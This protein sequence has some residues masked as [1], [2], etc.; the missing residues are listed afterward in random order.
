MSRPIRRCPERLDNLGVESI[1]DIAKR[2]EL[3]V[4]ELETEVSN[5]KNER[6]SDAVRLKESETHKDSLEKEIKLVK[7]DYNSLVKKTNSDEEVIKS[8]N[9]DISKLNIEIESR[10]K[11]VSSKTMMGMKN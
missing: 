9:E 10:K 11:N 3:A 1:R 4:L 2:L 8:L 5:L 7:E 6:K